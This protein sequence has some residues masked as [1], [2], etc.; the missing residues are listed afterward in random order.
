MHLEIEAYLKEIEDL[1]SIYS[2]SPE[3]DKQKWKKE[4]GDGPNDKLKHRTKPEFSKARNG[5]LMKDIPLDHVSNGS[6]RGISRRR[7]NHDTND[8]MLELWETAKDDFNL[9]QA[10]KDLNKQSEDP[11]SRRLQDPGSPLST[12]F[13]KMVVPSKFSQLKKFPGDGSL[14]SSWA[15]LSPIWGGVKPGLRIFF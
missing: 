7:R 9:N 8:Q 1:K 15:M 5:I 3:K 12:S 4:L 6:L 14:S 13:A 11:S 2:F 10:L